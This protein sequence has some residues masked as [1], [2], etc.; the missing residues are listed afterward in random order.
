MRHSVDR[1]SSRSRSRWFRTIELVRANQNAESPVRT[2]PLSGISVGSTTSNVEM[3]SLAT[4]RS[5]SSSSAKSSRTFPL[6]T[7]VAS[8]M[9]GFPL[10]DER[11]EPLEDGVDMACVGV[12]IEHRVEID[13]AGELAVGANELSEILLLIPGAE[14]VPLHQP[15]GL[16]TR[17]ARV[18]ER[19]KQT[20]AEEEAVAR[21]EVPAHALGSDD[22]TLD[23]PGEA[24]EHVVEGK[25]CVGDDH[26]LGRRVRDVPLVP[27][28]DVL[29]PD[30]GGRPNDPREAADALRNDGV[31]LVRHRGGTFLPA[32]ERLLD[33]RH[34]RAGE[35]SDLERELLERGRG[36][37]KRREQLGVPVAL[38]N[39]R[40]GGRRVE[41]EP[42]AGDPLDLGVGRGVGTDGTRELA[43]ADPLEPAVE[44]S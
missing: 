40:R 8:G 10:P 37:R 27:E 2:R 13:A 44:P 33:F 18:D 28:R 24:V 4:S 16:V 9:D 38:E 35:V 11:A 36:D 29:E 12:E 31:L 20:L 17:K 7:C 41:A 6:P 15:V 1:P 26:P 14:R 42:L 25:E 5:R 19:Q 32:T 34:F 23:E 39:L 21:L 3:R 22:Q 30:G 43:H